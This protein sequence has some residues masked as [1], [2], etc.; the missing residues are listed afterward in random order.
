[1]IHRHKFR[2]KQTINDG[3]KFPS[4]KHAAYYA[5]LMLRKRAGEVLFFL[6]E[7]PLHFPGGGRYVVDFI[8]FHADGSVHFVDVK[9][10]KT[11]SYL[12]KKR[13]IEH[14]FPIVIEEF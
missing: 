10:V 9:G 14:A 13:E 2:A 11:E 6:R 7:A 4:K 8:E 5:Q 1:M 12:F 3:I